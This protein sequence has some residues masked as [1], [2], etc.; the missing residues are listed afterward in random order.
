MK[1]NRNMTFRILACSHNCLLKTFDCGLVAKEAKYAKPHFEKKIGNRGLLRILY[2]CE[3]AFVR[4]N[5]DCRVGAP[6]DKATTRPYDASITGCSTGL[7]VL[8]HVEYMKFGKGEKQTAR[9]GKI[10]DDYP[11]FVL[12]IEENLQNSTARRLLFTFD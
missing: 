3:T 4:S 6:R 2:L 9:I 11:F 1:A 8:S 5:D 7:H 10:D 12:N